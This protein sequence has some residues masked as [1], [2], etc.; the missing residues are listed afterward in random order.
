[1]NTIA[2]HQVSVWQ[3]IATPA[4]QNVINPLLDA[5]ASR[6]TAEITHCRDISIAGGLS[7]F[8]LFLHNHQQRATAPADH[9]NA[10]NQCWQTIYQQLE[11]NHYLPSLYTGLAGIAWSVDYFQHSSADPFEDYNEELDQ[12][13]DEQL[14]VATWQGEYEFVMGL[15]GLGLYGLS[16]SDVA[17]GR[18]IAEKVIDHLL[19]LVKTDQNGSYWVT[20]AHSAYHEGESSDEKINLGLAHGMIGVIGLLTRAVK[21]HILLRKTVPLLKD[22]CRWML[23]QKNQ[24]A[25]QGY[26]SY[27]SGHQCQSRLG[28]CYGDLSNAYVL[29]KAGLALQN[30]MIAATALEIAQA[31][32]ARKL[33]DSGSVDASF[34]HGSAGIQFIYQRLYFYSKDEIFKQSAQYWLSETLK[35]AEGHNDLS[36]FHYYQGR[37]KAVQENLGLL[38]GFAGIG[39]VLLASVQAVEPDWDDVF[40]LG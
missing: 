22:A 27:T 25:E 31:T 3:P 11:Q 40:L 14:S 19:K 37:K 20:E 36:G 16:R 1:M 26:F 13:I 8:S 30:D 6:L 33:P 2:A 29:Y 24:N 34:C 18:H 35:L 17:S 7:G 23:A 15:T 4:Q 9:T 32:C 12:L 28:W 38:E 39:L 21:K 10:I 5:I